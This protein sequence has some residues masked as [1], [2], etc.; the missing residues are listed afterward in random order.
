MSKK[1]SNLKN[2]TA[3]NPKNQKFVDE[4]SKL[5]NLISS[6]NTII[7]D[8]KKI[9]VNNFRIRNLN[10]NL[11]TISKFKFPI[12]S[13]SQLIDIP[14]FGKGTIDRINEILQN[15]HLLEVQDLENIYSKI[16]NKNKIINELTAVV[17][18]G[19][20]IARDLIETYNIMSLDDLIQR[21]KKNEIEVNDK[22]KLG[23][24]Y[25]GKF[26]TKI[27]RKILTKIYTHI[28]NIATNCDTN[29]VINIC[30]SYRRGLP[31]SSDID[32]LVCDLNLLFKEDIEQSNTLQKLINCFKKDKLITDDITSDSVLTK[33]M[34]FC[35]YDKKIY[36]I[37][38]RLIPVESYYSALLYFTGSYQLNTIMRLKA[39]KLDYKLN[40]Y[41]LFKN[42]SNIPIILNSEKDIFDLLNMEYLEPQ[43]RNI[44]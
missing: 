24:K 31:E 29:L 37:D 22:I 11:I 42:K 10:K 15:N 19:E 6:E 43:Q 8:K 41:G 14:G 3:T 25:A 35:K 40:E 38:I 16:N 4:F 30:G 13:I 9:Q 36:R 26:E 27:S 28:E 18:I 20:A 5:I 12:T 1:N 2:L 23:L 33:Y 32:I 21:I 44:L 17:G 34:G 7:S 39:K